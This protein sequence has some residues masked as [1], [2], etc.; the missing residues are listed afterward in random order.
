MDQNYLI[1]YVRDEKKKNNKRDS[2]SYTRT[3]DQKDNSFAIQGLFHT[4]PKF[5]RNPFINHVHIGSIM[6]GSGKKLFA[7]Q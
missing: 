7:D 3:R 5:V 6:L 4:P 2:N 1:N